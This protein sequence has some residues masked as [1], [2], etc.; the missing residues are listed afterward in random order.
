LIF[1]TPPLQ[2]DSSDWFR[3]QHRV[4]V[5]PERLTFA[6]QSQTA[7]LKF[8]DEALKAMPHASL[9]GVLIHDLE[10]FQALAEGTP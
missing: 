8:W 5:F 6:G 10:G 3:V 9:A 1:R 4:T 2:S 7:V